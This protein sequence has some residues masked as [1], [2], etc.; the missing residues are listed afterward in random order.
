MTALLSL[1]SRLPGEP[2]CPFNVYVDTIAKTIR[3]FYGQ[4]LA[5]ADSKA[6]LYRQGDLAQHFGGY[7]RER[8]FT[9]W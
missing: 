2:R 6:P 4:D 7:M 3:P 5:Q 8:G 9:P 1:N